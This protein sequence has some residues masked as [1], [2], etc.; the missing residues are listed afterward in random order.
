MKNKKKYVRASFRFEKKIYEEF[1][2]NV[3]ENGFAQVK[4]LEQLM[5]AFNE[6]CKKANK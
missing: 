1:K 4:K 2:E 6:E 3:K 5:K